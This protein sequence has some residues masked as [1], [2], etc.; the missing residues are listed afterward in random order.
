MA[1]PIIETRGLKKYFKATK[2]GILETIFRQKVPLV[3]AVDNVNLQIAEK[4]VF[5]VVGESGSGKTTLGRILA[6]LEPPTAGEIFFM[7]EKVS[8][9]NREKVRGQTQMVFQN[10]Y[11]SLDPRATVKSIVTEPLLRKKLSRKEREGQ[12]ERVLQSVG[13][14]T[15]FAA[16]RP[17]DLSGGQRQRVAVARAIISSPSLVVLDEPTSALDAS[18]QSQVLNL[19]VR[20]RDELNFSYFYITHNIATAHYI[21]DRMATMYAGELVEIG[22]TDKVMGSPKH[23]YTQALLKSVPSLDTKEVAPPTGEVPSLINLPSGCRYHPRCPY[24]MDVCRTKDPELRKVEGQDV[25]CW[26][27]K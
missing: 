4:E 3:K 8:K 27:Y 25:A 1:E 6:T 23:P 21:S 22:P 26:L 13:L 16:R 18:V 17:R 19:L 20:L 24:A 10:P 2:T 14:E 12:L 5:A 11:E 9:E 15:G 7:G